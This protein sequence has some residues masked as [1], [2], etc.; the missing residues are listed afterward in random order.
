MKELQL[1][2]CYNHVMATYIRCNFISDIVS[3]EIKQYISKLPK[4]KKLPCLNCVYHG[5][6]TDI[7]CNFM[8]AMVCQEVNATR[9]DNSKYKETSVISMQT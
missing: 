7:R 5:V 1:L 9:L 4:R 6:A 8:T 2:Q 3:S